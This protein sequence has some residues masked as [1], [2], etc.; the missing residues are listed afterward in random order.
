[1]PKKKLPEPWPEIPQPDGDPKAYQLALART[2]QAL[3][4][5]KAV[6]YMKAGQPARCLVELHRALDE[7]SICRSPLLDGHQTQ[8]ELQDLYK[9]HL[10]NTQVPPNFAVLLQMREMLGIKPETAEAIEEDVMHADATF[11]I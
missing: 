3:Y 6:S 11:S 7:N 10:K 8:E 4:V 9:V 2:R 5:Q 1:L